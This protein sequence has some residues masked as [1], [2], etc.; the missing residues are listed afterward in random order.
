MYFLLKMVIFQPAMLVYQRVIAIV[1]S[2]EYILPWEAFEELANSFGLRQWTLVFLALRVSELI[3]P[4]GQRVLSAAISMVFRSFP[5]KIKFHQF[6]ASSNFGEDVAWK[7]LTG[8]WQMHRF[9][10]FMISWSQG[11]WRAGGMEGRRCS[12][13][14][15]FVCGLISH[16]FLRS[17]QMVE[18]SFTTNTKKVEVFFLHFF[19]GW[20]QKRQEMS[21][22]FKVFCSTLRM[23]FQ[24]LVGIFNSHVECCI[25]HKPNF[26]EYKS[27][28]RSLCYAGPTLPGPDSTTRSSAKMLGTA[29]LLGGTFV[30]VTSDSQNQDQGSVLGFVCFIL[31][32]QG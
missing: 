30:E 31:E 3:V 1:A 28:S 2:Q 5:R 29:K 18:T 21:W 7:S 32:R 4:R 12:F 15:L 17:P 9:Q 13:Y 8:C 6:G 23:S 10:I 16:F 20:K 14:I 25:T 22:I 27:I 19:L 11:S 26:H 24:S